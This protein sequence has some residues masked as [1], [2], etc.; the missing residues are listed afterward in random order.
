MEVKNNLFELMPSS[1][2]EPISSAVLAFILASSN[3]I[4]G[5]RLCEELSITGT[6]KKV[7]TEKLIDSKVQDSRVDILIECIDGS[8]VA[9]ENKHWHRI[10]KGQLTNYKKALDNCYKDKNELI[11]LAPEKHIEEADHRIGILDSSLVKSITWETLLKAGNAVTDEG[12]LWGQ[13][14]EFVL[15]VIE[16]D[17]F[18]QFDEEHRNNLVGFYKVINDYQT[19]FLRRLKA[20]MPN[21]LF[22]GISGTTDYKG[23][24]I[25]ESEEKDK[26]LS[27]IHI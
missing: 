9:I 10:S 24:Y 1:Q 23:F 16:P 5:A 19:D 14:N 4:L 2:R 17:S 21:E 18:K 26:G 12:E 27:L 7:Y 13:L 15:S 3:S 25:G 8:V 20:L 22:S 11:L 6:I